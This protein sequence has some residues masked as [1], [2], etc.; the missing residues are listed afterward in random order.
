[1]KKIIK[2]ISLSMILILSLTSCEKSSDETVEN[3]PTKDNALLSEFNV[4]AGQITMFPNP[5]SSSR[6]NVSFTERANRVEL[7]DQSSRLLRSRNNTRSLSIRN[8]ARGLYTV[9]IVGDNNTESSRKL[10]IN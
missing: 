6:G 9:I 4:T 3:T 2:T 7:F 1:M 5:V 8:L 10:L